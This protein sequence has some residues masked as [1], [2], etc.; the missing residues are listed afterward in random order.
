MYRPTACRVLILSL[1][2]AVIGF[3]PTAAQD[4]PASPE[5]AAATQIGDAW[6]D[7]TYSRPIL[8][9]RNGY[10]GSG[11][12]YGQAANAGGPVWR[13]GANVTTRIKTEADLMIGGTTVPAGEYSFFIELKEGAWTAI[14]SKQGYMET[15][16][17]AKM[18]EG[19]TWGA[20]GYNAEHDVVRA[21]MMTSTE[22]FSIDQMT[23]LF[24]DVSDA[25]GAIVVMWDNQMGV[26]P[27]GV[28][29]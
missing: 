19:L 9:G 7:I 1:C 22:D 5:G 23:I 4:R 29:Q 13:V 17:R 20:Y 10:F 27:F 25:G 3:A 6:I 14:I 21:S 18:E 2:L 8:R 28:A 16:D 12:T 24:T 11:E 26:L 15:F